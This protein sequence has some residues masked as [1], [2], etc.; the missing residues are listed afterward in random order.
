[1]SD[2]S[3]TTPTPSNSTTPSPSAQSG[4]PSDDDW[5]RL[6]EAMQ[7]WGVN[8]PRDLPGEVA[9]SFPSGMWEDQ[10]NW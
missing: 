7:Q 6:N 5:Q 4:Q 10:K 2:A 1:M 8:D 3:T 9:D